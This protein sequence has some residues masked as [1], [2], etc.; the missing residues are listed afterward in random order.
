MATEMIRSDRVDIPS[1][2]AVKEKMEREY[3]KSIIVSNIICLQMDEYKKCFLGL[4]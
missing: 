1:N 3:H 4:K 2:F